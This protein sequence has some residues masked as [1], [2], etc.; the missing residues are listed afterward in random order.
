ML[1]KATFFERLISIA[2]AYP[3]MVLGIL[4][5]GARTLQAQDSTMTIEG[6]VV[7][8]QSQQPAVQTGVGSYSNRPQGNSFGNGGSAMND[9][10]IWLEAKSQNTSFV[11]TRDE[12]PTLD[13]VDKQF[14]PRLMAVRVGGTVQIH[15]S[16][17]VYHNVFSLSKTKRFDVGRRAPGDNRDVVFD[18]T[19]KV[20]V[21]CDIHS[22]MHAVILV[23]PA[24]TFAIKKISGDGGFQFT[25]VPKGFDYVLHLY[26][27]GDRSKQVD[28]PMTST[29]KVTL[30]TI[31]LG[32]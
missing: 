12:V 18:Q 6:R 29:D 23:V 17:P 25:D 5:F 8:Q 2:L 3:V 14:N 32:S 13:Q 11:Q 19:G 9:I 30:E 4:L 24:H 28:I 27:L 21:F 1:S 31:R 16:D 10:V 22:N 7:L 20:D 15:N 26:A